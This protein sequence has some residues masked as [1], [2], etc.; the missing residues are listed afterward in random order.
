MHFF[1]QLDMAVGTR[2]FSQFAKARH[3]VDVM[4]AQMAQLANRHALVVLVIDEIQHLRLAKGVGLDA[5]LNF[6]VTLVNTIGI[7]VITIGTMGALPLF[8]GDFRQARRANGLGSAVWERITQGPV[9]EHFV[10]V[11]WEYQWT[12]HITPLT[13]EIRHVLYEE[14]QGVI[15]VLV[16]LFMLAQLQVMEQSSFRGSAEVMDAQLFRE[17]AARHFKI[18]APGS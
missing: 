13:D 8:Q 16:K 10:N 6:L 15:D 3:P 2:T 7:P 9:W 5:L 14:S 11:L 17:T 1:Q 18:I 4:M 12:R